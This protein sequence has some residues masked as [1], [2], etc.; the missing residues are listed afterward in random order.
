LPSTLIPGTRLGA[1][2]VR[3]TLGEGGMGAVYRARDTKLNRDVAIKVLLP[4]VASNPERLAR[5]QR[6]AQVLAAL[7][8]P[9]IAQIYGL[10]EKGPAGPFLVLELVEGATLADRIAK[11]P[12]PLDEALPI[13]RQIA[14]ALE[15][16]HEQGIIHRDL[17][18]ANIHVRDDGTVKVLDFGLAKALDGAGDA[19]RPGGAVG[20]LSN[21]PTLTSPALMTGVGMLL[22]TAAYMSPEQAKGR[23]ADRR[24]DLWAF[25]CVLYEMLAGRPVFEGESAAE[26]LAAA[27]TGE[28]NLAAL[29]PSTPTSVVRVI[30][31]CLAKERRAR[32]AD[33][34]DA[35][36][37]LDE[38]VLE[39][40]VA[41]Q[42]ASVRQSRVRRA[43]PWGVAA[44]AIVAAALTLRLGLTG[45]PLPETR[46]DILTPATSVP[47]SFALS[48]DGRQVVFSA[49]APSG[50]EQLWLR[51]LGATTAR[52]LAG[53]EGGLYPFWSPD[54][55]SIGFFAGDELKRWDIDVGVAGSLT[56]VARGRGGSW[57]ADGTI[58]FAPNAG[59]LSEIRATGG[60]VAEAT[61]LSG[62]QTGHRFPAFLPDGRHFLFLAEGDVES[63]GI[64]LGERGGG[65]AT[66]LMAG[67]SNARYLE[68]G[69]LLWVRQGG[70][71]LAQRLDVTRKV[72]TGE[73]RVV[74]D[75][76]AA[77]A[78]SMPVSVSSTGLIAYR[79]L[80]PNR[81][82]LTWVERDGTV[83]GIVP[84]PGDS[85]V[86]DPSVSPDGRLVAVSRSVGGNR[87]IWLLDGARA[88]RFTFDAAQERWPMWSPD[89]R[90]L[91]FSSNRTGVWN[92]FVRNAEGVSSEE[93]LDEPS[94][95]AVATSWT[96]DGRSIV[97]FRIAQNTDYDVWVRPA[98]T[99]GTPR[100]LLATPYREF[101]VAS[102]DGRWLAFQSNQSGRNEVYVAPLMPNDAAGGGSVPLSAQWQVSTAGGVIPQWRPDSRELFYLAPDGTMMA[103]PV[104]PRESGA[105]PG[106]P[107]ALFRTRIVGGGDDVGMGPQY[108]AL[109][110]R[111][112]INREADQS[113]PIHVIQNWS[114][115]SK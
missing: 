55:R 99:T 59:P 69:W 74:A 83:S 32:L 90:R 81:R 9:H 29:P 43:L 45:A 17:K 3:S 114:S 91:A 27:L 80:A 82:V 1:Y 72:L 76:V 57:S 7:N 30:R 51:S 93:R 65:E 40:G 21:S 36:M 67:G 110:D 98:A 101:A 5:F 62:G 10:E 2:E 60:P 75:E 94:L 6:E 31:R 113:P 47:N 73:P 109:Q 89:G 11:G 102:P 33:A 34:S 44:T 70:G 96:S 97:Y 103:V 106:T 8:H 38:A 23:P 108:A 64:Y 53:S 48:P 77:G 86:S 63:R 66:R 39:A 78:A 35:R 19:A 87:D 28:P 52:P 104:M 37:D 61:R 95:S 115:L 12:I 112:L 50:V 56:R 15:A 14:E 79:G 105:R 25:G 13:A 111:F 4:D 85:D 49:F 58:L 18:P 54:S 71:L 88:V 41:T 26:V 22:G 92:T 68:P 84:T 100:P 46:L 20:V 107:T 42:V 16:A 24:S